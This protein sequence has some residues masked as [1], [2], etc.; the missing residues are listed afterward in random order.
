MFPTCKSLSGLHAHCKG[1]I[2]V[3]PIVSVLLR[4]LLL[5][6]LL[7]DVSTSSCLASMLFSASNAHSGFCLVQQNPCK[8]D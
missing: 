1:Q 7:V 5:F 3:D 6:L 2:H 8:S 4:L